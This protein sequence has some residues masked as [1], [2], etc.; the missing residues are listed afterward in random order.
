M[1]GAE[2][3]EEGKPS[4]A[5]GCDGAPASPSHFPFLTYLP[6]LDKFDLLG[7]IADIHQLEGPGGQH[8]TLMNQTD[9]SSVSQSVSQVGG[10]REQGEGQGGL[11]YPLSIFIM[12]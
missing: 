11:I 8:H 6:V 10:A 12:P 2:I 7:S 4:R 1:K 3:Q 9:E 5:V